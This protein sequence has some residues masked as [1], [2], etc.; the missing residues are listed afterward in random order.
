ALLRQRF[1]CIF[2]MLP[3]EM[4]VQPEILHEAVTQSAGHALEHVP[5]VVRQHLS[6]AFFLHAIEDGAA[7]WIIRY[8]SDAVRRDKAVQIAAIKSHPAAIDFVLD[9]DEEVRAMIALLIKNSQ[10]NGERR[11]TLP[12]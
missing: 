2:K 5:E 3:E 4:Q 6:R 12:A 7:G 8:G 1:G 11:N 9:P 10:Q